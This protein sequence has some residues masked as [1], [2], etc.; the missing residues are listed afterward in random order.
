MARTVMHSTK[1]LTL[2]II[3]MEERE[4]CWATDGFYTNGRHANLG[5][6]FATVLDIWIANEE[7][8][9]R[10]FLILLVD[11]IDCPIKLVI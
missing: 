10:I 4:Q 8:L 2:Q 1:M 5:G 6:A 11:Y 7:K 3:S 9:I